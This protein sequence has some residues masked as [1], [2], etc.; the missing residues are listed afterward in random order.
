MSEE[1]YWTVIE[2]DRDNHLMVTYE[3]R[4]PHGTMVLVETH[5][6]SCLATSVMFVPAE[7]RPFDDLPVAMRPVPMPIPGGGA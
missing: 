1:P 5:W 6:N 3:H 4:M 7:A 2:V